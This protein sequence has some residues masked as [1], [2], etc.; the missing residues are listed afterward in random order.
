[1]K[2]VVWSNRGG[3]DRRSGVTSVAAHA[4]L[5]QADDCARVEGDRGLPSGLAAAPPLTG[6]QA[7]LA[8]GTEDVAYAI[9]AADLLQG[10]TDP[11]GDTLSG[12][13]CSRPTD[14][15]AGGGGPSG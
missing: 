3:T 4:R 7:V 14:P 9:A 2:S 6:A 5:I 10:F 15:G 11:E 12:R 8:A 13:A 1:M